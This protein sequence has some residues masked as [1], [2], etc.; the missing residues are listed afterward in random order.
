MLSSIATL[1][2]L[3]STTPRPT[4]ATGITLR[5]V[6][7]NRS[8]QTPIGARLTCQVGDRTTTRWLVTGTSYLAA[9]DLR[10]SFGLGSQAT[11]DRLEIRWPSGSTQAWTN[12]A[13]DRFVVASEGADLVVDPRFRSEN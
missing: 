6:G 4:Q 12:V 3:C 10:I 7:G 13:A 9:N 8:G 2:P 1:R 11:I 5:L